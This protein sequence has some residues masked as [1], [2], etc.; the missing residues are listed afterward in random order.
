MVY[1]KNKRQKY[2]ERDWQ[3]CR[4]QGW[5]LTNKILQPCSN[6]RHDFRKT[7]STCT[8]VLNKTVW[9][10]FSDY[11]VD[12]LYVKTRWN[13]PISYE[14]KKNGA[15]LWAQGVPRRLPV[16][17]VLGDPGQ[18]FSAECLP[19]LVGCPASQLISHSIVQKPQ[20]AHQV[21]KC[22]VGDSMAST[23]KH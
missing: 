18:V 7:L 8:K 17:S 11:R 22:P 1:I 6:W 5:V 4:L 3:W 14:K 16:F 19:H 13:L 10:V 2:Q 21:P 23:T 15:K 12:S 9:R 20:L